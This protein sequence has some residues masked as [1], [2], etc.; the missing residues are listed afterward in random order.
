[1]SRKRKLREDKRCENC[2]HFVEKRF[3][4]ECGQENIETRQSFFHLIKH[5]A[6]DFVHY[7]GKFWKTI[8]Y[9]LFYPAK[10]TKEYMA[11]KR[12]CYVNPVKLYIFISFITFF[13]LAVLPELSEKT[14]ANQEAATE[15]EIDKPDEPPVIQIG[16]YRVDQD[17]IG[18]E[19]LNHF[20]KAIFFYMP[21]FAF[22]LWL[23][24]NKKKRFYFDHSIYTLHYFSFILLSILLYTLVNWLLSLFHSE[25]HPLIG[26]VMFGYFIYYFFHSHRRFYQERKAVSR[27]KCSI[28]FGINTFCMIIFLVLYVIL[29][30]IIFSDATLTEIIHEIEVNR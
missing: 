26:V 24:H 21:V 17:K 15:M 3:C 2:G 1:M 9:L 4:P 7:D 27:L 30:T 10:L 12:N 6:G 16:V 28:L 13:L 8:W 19:F 29:V 14:E 18:E 20:P 22:W 5:F 11:G 25:I 23:F